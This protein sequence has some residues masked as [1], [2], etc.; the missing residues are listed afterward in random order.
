[1]TTIAI[2]S[3]HSLNQSN[4]LVALVYWRTVAGVDGLVTLA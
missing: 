1:M 3:P 2:L 4:S